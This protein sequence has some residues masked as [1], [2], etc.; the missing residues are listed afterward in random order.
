MAFQGFGKLFL[1]HP[2]E[3]EI[4]IGQ[5]FYDLKIFMLLFTALDRNFHLRLGKFRI[6]AR[7]GSRF[8]ENFMPRFCC[9]FG[10]IGWNL[11]R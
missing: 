9:R 1:A 11:N 8:T 7:H 6:A 5:N 3:E 10:E 2:V 4:S